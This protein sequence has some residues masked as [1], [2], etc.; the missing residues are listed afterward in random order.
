MLAASILQTGIMFYLLSLLLNNSEM[1]AALGMEH[2]S[3]YASLFFFGFLY[4]PVNTVVSILFHYLSRKHEYEADAYAV[5][6]TDDAESLISGLKALSQANLSNLTPHPVTVFLE[7][8]HPP[9]L[10]RIEAI[11]KL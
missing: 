1:F 5:A 6:S 7:Y 4:T 2:V 9:V 3:V 8:T 11:R 10:Q